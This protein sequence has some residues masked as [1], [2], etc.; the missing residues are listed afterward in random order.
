MCSDC[1]DAMRKC[2]RSD[3]Y[4]VMLTS[5]EVIIGNSKWLTRVSSMFP[6]EVINAAMKENSIAKRTKYAE[7][8]AEHP[9]KERY[10]VF[11]D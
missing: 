3:W 10:E 11:A 2:A 1:T 7:R 5:H 4:L 9:L 8:L 6:E